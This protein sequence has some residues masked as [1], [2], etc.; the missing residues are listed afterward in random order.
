MHIH[1]DAILYV[2]VSMYIDIAYI[3]VY[4]CYKENF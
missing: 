3:Y 2:S 4:E 1:I